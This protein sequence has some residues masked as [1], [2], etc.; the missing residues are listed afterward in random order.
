MVAITFPENSGAW[1]DISQLGNPKT[2]KNSLYKTRAVVLAVWFLVTCLQ[3]VGEVILYHQDIFH[4]WLFL[5][6]HSDF[7][8]Y[9]INMHQVHQLCVD[10]GL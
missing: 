6:T 2:E 9:I 1:F 3:V 7:H 10:D 5:H 4:D 8:F